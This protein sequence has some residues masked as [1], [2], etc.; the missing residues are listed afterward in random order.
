MSSA[1]KSTSQINLKSDGLLSRCS[2]RVLLVLEGTRSPTLVRQVPASD[3][4]GWDVGI[5]YQLSDDENEP[6]TT[7]A[8]F[9]CPWRLRLWRHPQRRRRCH[10]ARRTP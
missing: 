1:R 10:T 5:G 7:N 2:S 8:A 9:V 3:A 4:D 6:M